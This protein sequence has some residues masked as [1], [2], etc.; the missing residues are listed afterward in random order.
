MIIFIFLGLHLRRLIP[1]WRNFSFQNLLSPINRLLG[2]LHDLVIVWLFIVMVVVIILRIGIFM[3][4]KASL[5]LDRS[6]LEQ[7]WTVMPILVL[8]RVACP[9]ITLLCFQDFS[10]RH[11]LRDLKLTRNQWNWTRSEEIDHLLDTEEIEYLSSLV[12]PV[13]WR[14]DSVRVILSRTDVLHSLGLP[15]LGIKLDSIPGRLNSSFLSFT[16]QGLFPGSCYELCGRGHRAMPIRILKIWENS[17]INHFQFRTGREFL[18]MKGFKNSFNFS[19]WIRRGSFCNIIRTKI[20]R[21][22][23]DSIRS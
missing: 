10:E 7:I 15:S 4:P 17:E 20:V 12:S 23:P 8:V 9:S 19:P 5:L 22:K 13:L 2:S 11:P 16:S 1:L 14:E 21:T 6:Q 3:G 18:Y